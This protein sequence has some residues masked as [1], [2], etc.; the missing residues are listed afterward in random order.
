MIPSL[1]AGEKNQNLNQLRAKK[2]G[3]KKE[4]AKKVIGQN[5]L[6]IKKAEGF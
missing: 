2:V 4:S 3:R 5:Y 1:H 6:L